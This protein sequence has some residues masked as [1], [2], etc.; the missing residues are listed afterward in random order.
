[1][2]QAVQQGDSDLI[3]AMA[4]RVLGRLATDTGTC[5][6]H[7]FEMIPNAVDMANQHEVHLKCWWDR[8]K[9]RKNEKT[10]DFLQELLLE[11]VLFRHLRVATRKL[12]NQGVSTY[13]Y[14]PEEGQLLLI[15]EEPPL[16]TL[17]SPRIRQAFRILEDLHCLSRANNSIQISAGGRSILEASLA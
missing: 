1:L 16:P 11:W 4:A 5:Q 7:P 15:A 2:G 12:A 10:R 13:K 17:T 6:V 3:P 14:R 9:T 8:A